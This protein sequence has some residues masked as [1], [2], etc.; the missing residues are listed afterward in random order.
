MDSKIAVDSKKEAQEIKGKEANS[1]VEAPK[2]PKQ[3]LVFPKEV[4][5]IIFRPEKTLGVEVGCWEL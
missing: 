5:T 3:I 1:R 2:T 4:L